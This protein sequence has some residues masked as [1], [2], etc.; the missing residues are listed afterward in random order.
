MVKGI[1]VQKNYIY[2]K[3]RNPEREY[4]EENR[5]WNKRSRGS[6]TSD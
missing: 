3:T 6:E 4:I 2:K 1:S 5:T